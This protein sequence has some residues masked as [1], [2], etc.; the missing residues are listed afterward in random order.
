MSAT[1][2]IDK[3]GRIV[4]PKDIREELRLE[5]GAQ[6]TIQADMDQLTLRPV[7]KASLRRGRTRLRKEKGVWVLAGCGPMSLE[8]ANELVREDRS[9]REETV[10]GRSRR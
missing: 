8:K 4:I 1:I 5:P 2:T 6:L 9:Q 7:Q 10:S 3:A